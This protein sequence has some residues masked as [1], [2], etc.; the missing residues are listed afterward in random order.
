MIYILWLELKKGL[1]MQAVKNSNPPEMCQVPDP[2]A[3]EAPISPP[4]ATPRANVLAENFGPKIYGQISQEA[5]RVRRA[6]GT[7]PH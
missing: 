5:W 4:Q 6:I 2:G 7:T 1:G 3:K